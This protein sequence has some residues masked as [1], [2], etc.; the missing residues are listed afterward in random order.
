ME[1]G[2]CD[3]ERKTV[4]REVACQDFLVNLK[5]EYPLGKIPKYSVP[6]EILID[7][8]ILQRVDEKAAEHGIALSHQ[9]IIDAEIADR[10]KKRK[11]DADHTYQCSYS[12]GSE[13]FV[14]M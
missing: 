1:L 8:A 4:A 12:I 11:K 6:K 13:E 9:V 5:A 3:S 2:V 7:P 10:A 14:G